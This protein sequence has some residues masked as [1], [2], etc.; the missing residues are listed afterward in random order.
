[1]R[2]HAADNLGL[3]VYA[4]RA[5]PTLIETCSDRANTGQRSHEPC[6]ERPHHLER[7]NGVVWLFDVSG[8]IRRRRVDALHRPPHTVVARATVEVG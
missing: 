8:D 5:I 2:E 4:R 7:V 6:A 3:L 1:M